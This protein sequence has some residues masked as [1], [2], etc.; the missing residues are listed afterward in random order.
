[1]RDGKPWYNDIKRFIQHQE[2]PLG[3]SK[4]DARTLRNMVMDYYLDGEILYKKSFG[5]NLLRCL[6]KKEAKQTLQEV[7]KGI[8]ATHANDI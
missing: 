3:V 1:M 7:Y 2:Y 8:C 6:N 4:M 5:R